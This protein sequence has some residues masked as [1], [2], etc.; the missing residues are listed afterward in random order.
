MPI[1]LVRHDGVI[2]ATN[3][4]F[5]YTPE[6]GPRQ[7]CPQADNIMRPPHRALA[8]H[9]HD[10]HQQ[11]SPPANPHVPLQ[12]EPPQPLPQANPHPQQ[13]QQQMQQPLIHHMQQHP[14]MQPPQQQ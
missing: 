6:P 1:T 5:T 14:Q 8:E 9:P 10:P 4:T 2:Y 11:P 13:L 7:H 12:F 3:L